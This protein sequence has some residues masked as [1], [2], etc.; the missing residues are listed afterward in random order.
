MDPKNSVTSVGFQLKRITTEQFAILPES[1]DNKNQEISMG[2]GLNFSVDI[3]NNVVAV[4]VKVQFE[5]QKSPFIIVE[6]ANHF[7]I[8]EVA[9]N[10]FC[11]DTEKVVI[12]KGFATHLLVLTIGTIRGVLHGK[13]ENTEFN[14]FILP[15]VNATELINS[16]IEL[17]IKSQS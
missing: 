7:Y 11:L 10:S 14:N 1:Y 2:I 6:I 3:E 9:W 15:T 17:S 4:F 13:T 8:E 16:D 5:Q 12:P